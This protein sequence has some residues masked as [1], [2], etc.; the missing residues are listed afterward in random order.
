M[1]DVD[2]GGIKDTAEVELS[3]GK[4]VPKI[5]QFTEGEAR[6]RKLRYQITAEDAPNKRSLD[7][8][9]KSAM[10]VDK[11]EVKIH[12]VPMKVL[13]GLYGMPGIDPKD[14]HQ[15]PSS[16]GEGI[17]DLSGL[18]IRYTEIEIPKRKDLQTLSSKRSP[19]LIRLL[20]ESNSVEAA[21][22]DD[23]GGERAVVQQPR[24]FSRTVQEINDLQYQSQQQQDQELYLEQQQ[25]QYQSPQQP[26]QHYQ[27][28][29]PQHYQAQ[30]VGEPQY[31]SLEP[32][33][34]H[35]QQQGLEEEP[36][37]QQNLVVEPQVKQVIVSGAHRTP[38]EAQPESEEHFSEVKSYRQKG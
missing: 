27:S 22:A 37:E 36:Q 31:Q 25:Q 30:Q 5:K 21:V 18:R 9:Q 6:S 38:E 8:L 35:Q 24:G 16:K 11:A 3:G 4:A 14:L 7:D 19:L 32:Q 26:Q 13:K 34:H 33:Y 20:D 29:E 2:V 12:L 10:E 17:K 28:L 23:D 1:E 15:A